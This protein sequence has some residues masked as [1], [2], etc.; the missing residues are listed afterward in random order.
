MIKKILRWILNHLPL[1]NIIMFESC[2]DLGDNTKPVFDE[3]IRRGLNKK[4]K[5]V[6]VCY[7][8]ILDSYPK[9]KNVEYLDPG[10]QHLRGSLY[11]RTARC[12]FCCNRFLAELRPGQ[13][14]VYIPHGI[15]FKDS[16][17]YYRHPA[18]ISWM[19]GPA[20]GMNVET[21]AALG[22]KPEECVP[23]GYPRN[24][25]FFKEGKIN[26][27]LYFGKFKKY[28]VWYPTVK[29]F[30]GGKKTGCVKPIALIDTDENIERVNDIAKELGVLLIVKPHFAQIAGLVRKEEA[31]NIVFIDDSFFKKNNIASYDLLKAS[32]AMLSDY[33]SV[34]YDYLL[35]NKPIGL[36]WEDI[37]DY[38]KD[39][40]MTE[41]Y[42]YYAQGGE[43]IYNHSDLAEFL[44]RVANGVDRLSA[45]R[46]EIKKLI[47]DHGDGKAAERVADFLLSK[48]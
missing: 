24:D 21:G 3:F 15:P 48:M 4:Y 11:S 25:V 19:I 23:L 46:D 44:K 28:V 9:I 27:S 26:L 2:P 33:S 5:L 20:K 17:G 47:D 29:Q 39:P 40:G 34:Y 12:K 6:W 43:K 22:F 30:K 35:V 13:V 10:K 8:P 7:D 18:G 31:S 1:R 42:E 41:N 45:E 37:E 14:S 36:V 38:K 16:S 32:D